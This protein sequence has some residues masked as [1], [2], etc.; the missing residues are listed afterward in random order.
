MLLRTVQSLI[1]DQTHPELASGKQASI[2]K[3]FSFHDSWVDLIQIN[4]LA[5]TC[6]QVLS[7]DSRVFMHST[8]LYSHSIENFSE[9]LLAWA[10]AC[11]NFVLSVAHA[12]FRNW[13][14]AAYQLR[15]CDLSWNSIFGHEL[16]SCFF[17]FF[18]C[19][20]VGVGFSAK[21][22]ILIP[23]SFR[24]GFRLNSRL[25]FVSNPPPMFSVL[26][27]RNLHRT[28]PC[29]IIETYL[30][31]QRSQGLEFINA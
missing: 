13:S 15:S 14:N 3:K 2:A 21:S 12:Y 19:V 31:H 10:K 11:S 16:S 9:L 5:A 25:R 29:L 4:F 22:K 18:G 1:V 27:R 6:G 26:D 7:P 23:I 8:L 30:M 17:F 28:H 20:G 24:F